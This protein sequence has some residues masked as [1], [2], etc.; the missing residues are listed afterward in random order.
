MSN[1]GTGALHVRVVVVL[2]MAGVVFALVALPVGF[3][4]SAAG[5]DL[6]V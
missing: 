1:V 2:E 4:N 5:V 3:Q 6:R